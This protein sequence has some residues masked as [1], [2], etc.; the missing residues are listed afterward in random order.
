MSRECVKE[1][2]AQ[3]GARE[4]ERLTQPTDGAVEYAVNRRLLATHFPPAGRVL[5]LG[6][7]PGRYTIWLAQRGY[8]VTLADLSPNLLAIAQEQITQAGVAD[9]VE[10]I[11]KAD[12]C[13]LSR[14]DDGT[15]AAVLCLGPFYHLPEPADRIRAASELARVLQPGGI[16]AIALM[17]RLSF[18]R[19]TLALADE[20][21]HLLNSECI[22]RLLDK[23]VFEN[24]VPDRL[25]SGYGVDPSEV[26]PFFAQFGLQSL[27]LASSQGISVGLAQALADIEAT[28]PDLYERALDLIVQTASD[29]SILGMASHLLYITRKSL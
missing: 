18:V 9:H 27:M 6:G 14:W 1:Y 28:A 19:R 13:D 4:W 26:A 8:T 25:T 2:Y 24:D 23:G 21:P 17:P 10:A 3:F 12:A 29:P 5:D 11:V 22:T 16:A 15:F 20:R 7:G